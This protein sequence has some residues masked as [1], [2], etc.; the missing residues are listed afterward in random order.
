MAKPTKP[1]AIAKPH[2]PR[3]APPATENE[4]VPVDPTA[5][6]GND[7]EDLDDFLNSLK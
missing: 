7:E 5:A 3:P 1:P 4:T 2:T 6:A